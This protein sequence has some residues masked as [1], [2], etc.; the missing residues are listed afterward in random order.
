MERERYG[1]Y[2]VVGEGPP[3]GHPDK[4]GGALAPRVLLG[5]RGGHAQ[6]EAG[7][8][9]ARVEQQREFEPTA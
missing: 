4:R 6:S 9:E 7:R 2:V 8:S 1:A 3:A 5:L